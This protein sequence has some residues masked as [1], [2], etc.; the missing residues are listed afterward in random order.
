[1]F[2]HQP[3]DTAAQRQAGNSGRRDH[4]AR[5][6][7]V[8]RGGFTIEFP[9]RHTR[10]RADRAARGIHP[11]TLHPSEI[12][13][14]SAFARTVTGDAVASGLHRYGD[15]V[16]SRKQHGVPD[17]GRPG[18][19]DNQFRPAVEHAIPYFP[20]LVESRSLPVE[21]FPAQPALKG[22]DVI[23]VQHFSGAYHEMFAKKYTASR[24]RIYKPSLAIAGVAWH[25]SPR[26]L[27]ARISISSPARTTA[28]LPVSLV[29]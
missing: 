18:A 16:F 4:A 19:A 7:E 1:M 22:L 28:I 11:D 6:G 25:S 3:S 20:G 14:Q 10:L 23:R 24:V 26:S 13:Q 12:D 2:T 21:Q 8:E 5:G 29:K 27:T 15:P 17:V 9:P